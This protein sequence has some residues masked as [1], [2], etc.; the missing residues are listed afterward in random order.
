MNKIISIAAARE[1][2]QVS[3]QDAWRAYLAA[4][5]KAE[6]SRDIHDGIAAGKAWALW[7]HIFEGKRA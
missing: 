4:R 2:R 5:D 6:R 7:L 1:Q 3:E